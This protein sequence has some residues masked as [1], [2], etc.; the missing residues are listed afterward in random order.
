[1]V[2]IHK[3]FTSSIKSS[4]Q[5]TFAIRRMSHLTCEALHFCTIPKMN[6]FATIVLLKSTKLVMIISH[7]AIVLMFRRETFMNN[8]FNNFVSK[9]K[10]KSITSL[11]CI[12]HAIK[13]AIKH[14]GHMAFVDV[15]NKLSLCLF[16][17]RNI[18]PCLAEGNKTWLLYGDV[19]DTGIIRDSACIM[20]VITLQQVM[21]TSFKPSNVCILFC[22][23]IF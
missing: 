3:C 5:E 16:G 15:M 13:H 1:M 9:K 6:Y 21:C 17:K 23:I 22:Q 2:N 4:N 11:A 8:S 20:T 12:A 18:H 7:F 19:F 10:H 14:Y